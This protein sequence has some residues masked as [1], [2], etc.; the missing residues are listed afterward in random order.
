MPLQDIKKA[1]KCNTT[2]NWS[3]RRNRN[4]RTIR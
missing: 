1:I 2:N 4:I 3:I